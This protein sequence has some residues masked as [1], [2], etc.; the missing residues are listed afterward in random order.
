MADDVDAL[1]AEYERLWRVGRRRL[2]ETT[3]E[4]EISPIRNGIRRGISAVIRLSPSTAGR[5][6]EVTFSLH[7]LAGSKHFAY[8]EDDLHVT[9]RSLSYSQEF[10]DEENLRV[11]DYVRILRGVAKR[12][13]G[14]RVQ[15]QGL[16]ASSSAVM[17]QGWPVG[18][19]FQSFRQELHE[20]LSD[21]DLL[22]GPESDEAR[23]IAHCSLVV[24]SDPVY[25]PAKLIDFI[26]SHRDTEYGTSIATA[27][28][29]I[30]Y[31]RTPRR[32]DSVTIATIHLG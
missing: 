20:R 28:E 18:P 21:E 6:C 17:A 26:D 4:S 9:V 29:V 13:R 23:T 12:Y 1:R 16:T 15:F 7:A 32:V 27:I 2:G 24:F 14:F 31:E 10:A 3:N 30:R 22:D 8:R 25:K 11:A 19:P 5:L